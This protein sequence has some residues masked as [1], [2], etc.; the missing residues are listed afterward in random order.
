[1]DITQPN[2]TPPHLSRRNFI[3]QTG[4]SGIALTLGA[5]LPAGGDPKGRAGEGG[6]RIIHAAATEQAGP[7][8]ELMSW[9]SIDSAGQVTILSHRSEMGQGTYQAIPQMV[10]EELEVS[11]DKVTIGFAPANP[12]KFG[13]QPQEG[14]FSVRGWYQQLLRV[15]ASAREMLIET[16]AKQWNVP[17]SECYAENGEVIHRPSGKRLGYGSLVEE[18]SKL[19]P[20]QNVAIKE[21]KD[22]KIIGKPM[23]RQDIPLK[24]NGS[25]IFGFDTKLP[26]I[27][28]PVVKRHPRLSAT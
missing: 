19:P 21:R 11:L 7:E 1:M 6:V 22:Y 5:W 4:L 24:T 15:G 16:A 12:K 3:R 20:P 13:P 18:A 25:A 8:I 2:N 14:S 17:A 26:P 27:H 10:A 23:P 28:H 9:I